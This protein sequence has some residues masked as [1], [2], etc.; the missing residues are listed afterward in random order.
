MALAPQ[1][2]NELVRVWIVEYEDWEPTRWSDVPPAARAV[3]PIGNDCWSIDDALA[4]LEGFNGQALATPHGR[5]AIVHPVQLRLA[6]D[7]TPDQPCSTIPLRG[8]SQT[9]MTASTSPHAAD[10]L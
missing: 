7:L 6:G 8:R 10:S 5:W 4:F 1:R 2:P 3:A 9:G